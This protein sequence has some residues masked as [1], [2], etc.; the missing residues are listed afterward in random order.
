MKEHEF[1]NEEMNQFYKQIGQNVKELRAKKGVT[2]MQLANA[3]GHNSVGHIA[4]AE[5]NKYDKHFSI[6]NLYMI[7]KVL[8]VNIADLLQNT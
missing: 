4:K 1:T 8:E 5:L 2:Q 6:Q 7:A 3:I